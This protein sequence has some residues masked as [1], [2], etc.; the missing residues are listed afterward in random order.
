MLK[1]IILGCAICA[2]TGGTV[3]W[4]KSGGY[5]VAGPAAHESVLSFQ[6]MHSNAHLDSL[7]IQS[8]ETH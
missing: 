7:P 1:A 2:G 8:F 5:A 3:L 4:V 6:E